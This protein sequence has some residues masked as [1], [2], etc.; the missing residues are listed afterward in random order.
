[1]YKANTFEF[2][3]FDRGVFLDTESKT[4]EERIEETLKNTTFVDM[5]QCSLSDTSNVDTLVITI[6]YKEEQ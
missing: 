2:K 3:H 5:K 4:P 1:M 6:I